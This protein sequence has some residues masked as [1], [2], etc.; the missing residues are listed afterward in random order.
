MRFCCAPVQEKRRMRLGCLRLGV[1]A[2]PFSTVDTFGWQRDILGERPSIE[3]EGLRADK[4]PTL[5]IAANERR[6]D[7]RSDLEGKKSSLTGNC[8]CK[9]CG[10]RIW[11]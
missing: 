11:F 10:N 3:I 2:K 9:F 5:D 1:E 7:A 8:D 6:V 4:S